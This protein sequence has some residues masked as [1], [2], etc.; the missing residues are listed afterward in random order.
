MQTA[1]ET[2]LHAIAFVMQVVPIGSNISLL[3]VLW[4]MVNG[5]FLQS[6]G[7]LHPAL[8]LNGFSEEEIRRSWAAMRAGSWSINE[9]LEA[10][11]GFVAQDNKWSAR[12]YEGLEVLGVDMTGFWRPKLKGWAGKHYNSLARRA[13]PAVVFGVMTI[14]GAIHNQ[15]IPLLKY[16]LRSQPDT[17]KKTFRRQLLKKAGELVSLNQV[18]V[19]DAEFGVDEIQSAGIIRFVARLAVNCTALRNQLPQY[20]GRGRYPEYGDLIRPL[21]RQHKDHLI[22]ASAPDKSSQ[23]DYEGRR[24]RVDYWEDM[25]TPTTKVDPEAQTYSI[26]VYHDP[27]YKT[28]MVLATSLTVKNPETPYLIYRDRWP[29]EH[30]PLAAKQMIGLHRL[31]VFAPESCFRLPELGFLAG[32]ILTYV[33][34]VLPPFPTGF[35]DRTPKPTPGRLRRVLAKADFPNLALIYPELREKASVS[36]HLPKGV[37]AHRRQKQET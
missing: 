16:L 3:R 13:L 9:L 19:T 14:S 34:A 37:E 15:R 29:V 22:P 27:L 36:A 21:A 31:F 6:R 32:A 23:F 1:V 10:W 35:W 17:D 11:Q 4:V 12:R 20:K 5:S 7:A 24:I 26:Y 2:T 8:A 33:A 28:P 25:V 30:P 18:V